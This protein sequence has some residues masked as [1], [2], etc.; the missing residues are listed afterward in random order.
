MF[1]QIDIKIRTKENLGHPG[2][3]L[4]AWRGE[5]SFDSLLSWL[6]KGL[7]VCLVVSSATALGEPT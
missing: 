1:F 7:A 2:K 3:L 6:E 4:G 5:H